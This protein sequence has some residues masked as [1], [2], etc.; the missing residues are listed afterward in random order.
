MPGRVGAPW[1]GSFVKAVVEQS[2]GF[3]VGQLTRR[4]TNQLAGGVVILEVDTAIQARL[5][6]SGFRYWRRLVRKILKFQP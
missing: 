5:S 4:I 1:F 2:L 6:P 3:F